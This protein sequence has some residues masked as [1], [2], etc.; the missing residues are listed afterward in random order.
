[1]TAAGVR[2]KGSRQSRHGTETK[3]EPE[4]GVRPGPGSGSGRVWAVV[5]ALTGNQDDR[6]GRA[7]DDLGG[8]RAEVE[9]ADG[10]TARADDEEVPGRP[11]DI[12]QGRLPGAS[13]TELDPRPAGQLSRG[14]M[15][16]GRAQ[17]AHR[18]GELGLKVLAPLVGEAILDAGHGCWANS[19]RTHREADQ[20]HRG[21]QP[22]GED[23]RVTDEAA[24]LVG[25]SDG[26]ADPADPC[27]GGLEATG[28]EDDWQGRPVEDPL[29]D[30][31]EPYP[32]E[33]A[34]G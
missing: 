33:D 3:V 15:Q 1:M 7:V 2:V 5:V 29:G 16:C 22:V 25:A 8:V 26:D 12:P 30:T 18:V 28:G 27:P 23:R 10:A 21:E 34:G 17:R 14:R 20:S 11:G 13:G 24:V 32:P 19:A 6:H 9:Q 31:S 4:P